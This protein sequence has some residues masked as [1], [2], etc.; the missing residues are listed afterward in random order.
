MNWYKKAQNLEIVDNVNV[1]GKGRHY[2]DYGHDIYEQQ[3]GLEEVNQNY[4]DEQPNMMWV[5]QNGNIETKPETDITPSHR[6]DGAW[7]FK[8]FLDKL[9]TGRYSPSEKVITVL[10]PHEGVGTF[11]DIPRSLR[12]SLSRTFPDAEKIIRY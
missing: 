12:F 6:S 4:Q 1:K 2:T 9:Y 8:S 5:Y 10:P 11:I 3:E 7:G